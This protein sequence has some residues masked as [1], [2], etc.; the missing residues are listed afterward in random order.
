MATI[1]DLYIYPIKSLGGI[2]VSEARLTDRGLEHDRRWMLIDENNRFLTQRENPEMALLQTEFTGQGI[3]VFHKHN[4][5]DAVTFPFKSSVYETVRVV[6]WDDECDAQVMKDELNKWFS[7]H[8]KISCR[9][10]YMPDTSLRKVE[11]Q[12]ALRNDDITNFS[13][14]Y[15][16]LMISEASLNDLNSRL[17][18]KLPMNRF[19]P[20]I[21]MQ[22]A[23]AYDEDRLKH[24][25]INGVDFYGVKLCGRCVI[26]TINQDNMARS[27][28][29]LKTLST[30]RM[31]NNKIF[32]GQNILYKGETI[33]RA[34]DQI[35]IKERKEQPIFL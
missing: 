16:L 27:K 17:D 31:K 28:E 14:G 26:T 5:T 6:V 24:F 19:R 21:V 11:E 33:L 9:L 32:F 34:G 22:G 1:S 2:R 3:R 7:K 4:V 29:P 35:E 10:V 20:N 30:Y 15:P 25:I 8:L 12:Y 18:E 23:E 13:D